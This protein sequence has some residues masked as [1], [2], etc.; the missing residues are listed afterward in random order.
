MNL[1]A[2][3][4]Q[5]RRHARVPAAGMVAEMDTGFQQLTQ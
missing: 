1:V 2:H 5:E 3:A 4:E